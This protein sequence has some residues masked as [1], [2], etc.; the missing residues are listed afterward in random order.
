ME[1]NGHSSIMATGLLNLTSDSPDLD[2]N[3][4][5]VSLHGRFIIHNSVIN[6]ECC[7]HPLTF[8]AKLQ[9]SREITR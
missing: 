4:S 8:Q 2:E 9:E 7:H 3:L 5:T 1:E 6:L